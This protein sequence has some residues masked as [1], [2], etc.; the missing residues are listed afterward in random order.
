MS[1]PR[2]RT[3]AARTW[4]H[5]TG[6]ETGDLMARLGWTP[7]HRTALD[8]RLRT[9]PR[10]ALTGSTL[11]ACPRAFYSAQLVPSEVEKG[12]RPTV[13]GAVEVGVNFAAMRRMYS[14]A[15]E[16]PGVTN[17]YSPWQTSAAQ[18]D[19]MFISFT[20]AIDDLYPNLETLIKDVR[21]LRFHE[22]VNS[23][24]YAISVLTAVSKR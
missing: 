4:R 20:N 11:G 6:P 23:G 21:I 16:I 5:G 13:A 24:D 12:G 17:W 19:R 18:S 14:W 1:G 2:H 10:K 22:Q 7:A 15:I 3:P 8:M 9:G